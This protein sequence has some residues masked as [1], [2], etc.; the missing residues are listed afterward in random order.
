[1]FVWL[2]KGRR[3][4]EYC[5]RVAELRGDDGIWR[6]AGSEWVRWMVMWMKVKKGG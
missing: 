5:R 2:D 4:V 1:M 3:G 6:V